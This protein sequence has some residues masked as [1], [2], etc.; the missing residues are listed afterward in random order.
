MDNLPSNIEIENAFAKYCKGCEYCEPE[1]EELELGNF[2]NTSIQ[3]IL[4]C[5]HNEACERQYYKIWKTKKEN[6]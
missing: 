5:R 2:M 6:D 4:H 3:Y 1:F